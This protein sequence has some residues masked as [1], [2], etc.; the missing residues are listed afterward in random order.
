MTTETKEVRE[1]YDV[2]IQRRARELCDSL[3]I[4]DVDQVALSIRRRK[5]PAWNPEK[6]EASESKPCAQT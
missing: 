3:G 2:T 5:K 1:K 4:A 6:R